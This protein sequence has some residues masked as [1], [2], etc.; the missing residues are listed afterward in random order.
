MALE[1]VR[2]GRDV[3]CDREYD[4]RIRV[5]TYADRVG[6]DLGVFMLPLLLLHVPVLL[7]TRAATTC[8]AIVLK[9]FGLPVTPGKVLLCIEHCLSTR[10]RTTPLVDHYTRGHTAPLVPHCTRSRTAP[11]VPHCTRDRTAPLVPH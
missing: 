4:H 10:G 7:H 6:T 1:A 11:L 3:Y 5:C 9:S 2:R 8:D